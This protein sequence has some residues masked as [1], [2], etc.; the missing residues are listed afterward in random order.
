MNTLANVAPGPG[1]K[2]AIFC[3]IGTSRFTAI[4]TNSTPKNPPAI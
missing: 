1:F 3:S 2:I 4:S